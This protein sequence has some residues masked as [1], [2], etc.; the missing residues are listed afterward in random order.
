MINKKEKTNTDNDKLTQKINEKELKNNNK[1]IEDNKG[2]ITILQTNSL[3]S[4]AI[5]MTSLINTAIVFSNLYYID[6]PAIEGYVFYPFTK[7]CYFFFLTVINVIIASLSLK[8][9]TRRIFTIIGLSIHSV[10]ALFLILE[11]WFLFVT[12]FNP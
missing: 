9:K 3:V 7:S 6:L 10:V 8:N 2:L 11:M 1:S 12:S 5:F 4:I